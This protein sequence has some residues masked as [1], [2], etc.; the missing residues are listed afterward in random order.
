MS[1]KKFI[2][3][4][5]LVLGILLGFSFFGGLFILI[6]SNSISKQVRKTHSWYMKSFFLFLVKFEMGN[7]KLKNVH[8]R[9][10]LNLV[11][12]LAWVM[13]IF[14]IFY[15]NFVLK[16]NGVWWKWDILYPTTVR[17]YRASKWDVIAVKK[18][19]TVVFVQP[20]LGL[21][22]LALSSIQH[23][24]SSYQWFSTIFVPGNIHK[25]IYF[26]AACFVPS[27]RHGAGR[28]T[29]WLVDAL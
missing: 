9:R 29:M 25:I 1:N 8:S 23:W 7:G 20:F 5:I 16:G 28:K 2:E 19:S 24:P 10:K 13:V 11:N 22:P 18:R 4:I 15:E 26:L 6:D 21:S 27:K 12:S 14:C 17:K 3:I